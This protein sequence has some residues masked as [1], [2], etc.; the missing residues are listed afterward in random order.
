MCLVQG[1][2]SPGIIPRGGISGHDREQKFE[3]KEGKGTAGATETF[4]GRP[5]VKFTIKFQLWLPAHF[6]AWGTFRPLLKYDPLKSPK[7]RAISIYHPALAE[8]EIGEVVVTKIGGLTAADDK[9]L[10]ERTIE[11]LEYAPPP[12]ASVTSTPGA[13]KYT[14]GK[15]DPNGNGTPGNQPDPAVVKLQQKAAALAKQAEDLA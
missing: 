6:A 14:T 9:G 13:T 1:V 12:N 4:N 15:G 8:N 7:E 3:V 10:S 5:P 2:R 11:F